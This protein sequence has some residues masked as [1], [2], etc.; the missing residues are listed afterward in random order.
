MDVSGASL[1]LASLPPVGPASPGYTAPW[2]PVLFDSWLRTVFACSANV[3]CFF[4]ASFFALPAPDVERFPSFVAN[5]VI[6][7]S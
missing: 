1:R 3:V 4:R 5:L 7:L 2:I 6:H